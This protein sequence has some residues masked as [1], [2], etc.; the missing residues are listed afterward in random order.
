MKLLFLMYDPLP[1]QRPDVRVLFGQELPR[2]GVHSDLVGQ[3][4]PQAAP[5]WAWPAGELQPAGRERKGLWGELL[6]PLQDLAGMRRA[7]RREHRVIQVR[8]KIR[9]GL[10]ALCVARLTGRRLA[11][12]MSFPFAA[13]Y[14]VRARQL[15]AA[16]GPWRA[17]PHALRAL[18]AGWACERLLLPRA[19]HVFVQSEAMLEAVAQLG[20]ARERLTAVPMGV[21]LALLRASPRG[22]GERPARLQGRRVLA[23]LG[24]MG[25]ARQSDFLL[26]VLRELNGLLPPSEPPPLLLLIGDAPSPDEQ[27]WL[28]RCIADS[29]LAQQVWLTGWLPQAEALALLRE[30]ELGLSPVPRGELYDV[31]SPTKA[32]EYLALGLP[33]VGNDIPDQRLV[34]ERSGAG[35]CVPMQARPFAQACACILNDP[36]LAA[37]LAAKGPPWVAAHRG[38]ERLAALVAPVYRRLAGEG[39]GDV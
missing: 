29:G 27:D 24:V 5:P 20:V 28:R 1:P 32:V 16:R 33:C 12:W 21:D 22:A 6:R 8:D 31:S 3:I 19:D 2:L 15:R 11:Y 38:Y 13:G 23:Y 30:A 18:L 10:L 9:T 39:D 14:R 7:L 34:L 37:E 26:E 36:A 35:L 17:A 4:S 25:P